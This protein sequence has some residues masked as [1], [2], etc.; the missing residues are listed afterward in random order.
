MSNQTSEPSGEHKL[1]M[2]ALIA[3]V[4]GSMLGGGVFSLPQN[5]AA[6]SAIGPVIIAWII[7]GIGIYF[8]ANSFRLFSDLRPDLKAGVYMY[9]QAGFGSF[10]GFNVAWGY[11]LR[12]FD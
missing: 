9:A 5:T 3:I 1:G 2:V 4:V 8:I 10:I 6:N 11:W 7:A 12:H